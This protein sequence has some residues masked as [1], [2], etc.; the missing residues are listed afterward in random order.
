MI[1]KGDFVIQSYPFGFNQ[2]PVGSQRTY[3]SRLQSL[4]L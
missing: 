3:D 1:L 4:H 2:V